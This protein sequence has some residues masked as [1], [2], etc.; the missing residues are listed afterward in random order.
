[1]LRSGTTTFVEF[2]FAERNGFEGAMNAIVESGIRGCFGKSYHG[3]AT[4]RNSTWRHLGRGFFED[5]R[6][7]SK[8]LRYH[9]KFDGS[10]DG[11]VVAWFSRR[12]PYEDTEELYTKM[13][14]A[15][16]EE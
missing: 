16:S 8:A 3:P 4:I 2:L 10:R 12:N 14:K 13:V 1:M 15:D 7:L 9:A 11:R 6:S 5:E